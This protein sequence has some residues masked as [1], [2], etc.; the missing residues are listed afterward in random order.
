MSNNET[1][2]TKHK[3]KEKLAKN[4]LNFTQQELANKFG[5][6]GWSTVAEILLQTSYWLELNKESAIA[7]QKHN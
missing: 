7:Q 3:P 6:I 2:F 5:G 1:S 4:N